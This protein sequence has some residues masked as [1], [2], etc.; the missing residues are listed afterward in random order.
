MYNTNPIKVFVIIKFGYVWET[1]CVSTGKYKDLEMH[2][3]LFHWSTK[4][5]VSTF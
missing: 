4:C 1:D 5:I 2:G 3:Q